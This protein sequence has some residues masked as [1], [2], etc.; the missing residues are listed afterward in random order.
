MLG[1]LQAVT[2]PQFSAASP[3]CFTPRTLNAPRSHDAYR[4]PGILMIVTA[5]HIGVLRV[6]AHPDPPYFGGSG[7]DGFSPTLSRFGWTERSICP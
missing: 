2:I 1:K 4:S 6:I 5:S 7:L 3:I